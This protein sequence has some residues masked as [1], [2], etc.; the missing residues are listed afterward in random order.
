[1][2]R[3]I[4]AAIDLGPV[5]E[6]VLAS[7]G[8]LA[9]L[10]GADLH[11]RHVSTSV[12]GSSLPSAS[13]E[14]LR[15]DDELLRVL[16]ERTLP[17][18]E[19]ASVRVLTGRAPEAILSMAGELQADLIVLG[20]HAQQDLTARLFGTTADRV[21]RESRL[22]VL[23]AQG[24]L[25]S[26]DNVVIA[27]DFSDAAAHATHFAARIAAA[28]RER[29]GSARSLHLLHVD[30]VLE[31][32]AGHVWEAGA[33]VKRLTA[34]AGMLRDADADLQVSTHAVAADDA[35]GRIRDWAAQHSADLIIMGTTGRTRPGQILLGSVATR[36]A[37]TASCPVLLVPRPSREAQR[38]PGLDAV[39][40]GVDF[41]ATSLGAADWALSELVPQARRVV[42]HVLEQPEPSELATSVE[43]VRDALTRELRRT[44]EG[45]MAERFPTLKENERRIVAGRT[46]EMLVQVAHEMDADLIVVGGHMH[47]RGLWSTLGSTAERL[48]HT[49]DIPVLVVKGRPARPPSR[50]LAAV[51]GT[52]FAA[53]VLRW[54]K[55]FGERYDADVNIVH[56]L[57][58]R[59]LGAAQRVSG[60]TA[61]SR[62]DRSFEQQTQE[63]LRRKADEAGI[64]A[65]AEL[66]VVSGD[67]T[68]EL[69]ALQ[70]R[71]GADLIVVGSHGAGSV[72][73]ALLG[74][75]AY[76]VLRGSTCPVFVVR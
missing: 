75:V 62:V 38:A 71:I 34:A 25:D 5:A 20:P 55:L 14:A 19:P 31:Q 58:P 45:H 42:L 74:S 41:S 16:V 61:R 72:G 73:S 26:L 60:M 12:P 66:H 37:R 29:D 2:I 39:V 51:D 52:R 22:P 70:Q 28:L 47:P 30:A 6:N 68:L 35:A 57:N 24:R 63:W 64:E 13:T 36:V 18:A 49:S 69:L 48:V 40:A 15:R 21:V 56:V 3:K 10:L 11:V 4:L 65:S 43:S 32:I 50:I 67:P 53:D 33:I 59:W 76:S 7:A 23:I 9:R 8:T 17:G 27:T 46:A 44:T 54:T 1:V